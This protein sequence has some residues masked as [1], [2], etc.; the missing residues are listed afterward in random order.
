MGDYLDVAQKIRS[1][2]S[3]LLEPSQFKVTP[4]VIE[5]L[6]DAPQDIVQI[7]SDV[8]AMQIIQDLT[9]TEQVYIEFQ[10]SLQ[11]GG[12]AQSSTPEGEARLMASINS[13]IRMPFS[14]EKV[15]DSIKKLQKELVSLSK[16]MD[17]LSQRMESDKYSRTPDNIQVKD[18]ETLSMWQSTK[19]ALNQEL[20]KLHDIQGTTTM[21]LKS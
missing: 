9:N 21:E 4:V 16:A 15:A 6:A 18:R 14:D 7:W 5:I 2:K 17:K 13:S 20:S 1:A 12:S 8:D 11:D 10:A 3:L 19:E